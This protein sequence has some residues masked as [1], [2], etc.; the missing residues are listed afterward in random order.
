[1]GRRATMKTTIKGLG[2]IAKDKNRIKELERLLSR[3]IQMVAELLKENSRLQEELGD[4]NKQRDCWKKLYRKI[5]PDKKV[6]CDRHNA[7]VL[8]GEIDMNELTGR[9]VDSR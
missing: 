4:V 8:Y 9:R 6:E 2:S 5:R 7:M 3:E 1:M